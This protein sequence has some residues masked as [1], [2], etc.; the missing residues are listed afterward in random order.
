MSPEQLHI[1]QHSLGVDQYGRGQMYRDHFVTGEG[2]ADHP[3][4]MFLVERGDMV[5]YPSV[6]LY[7]GMDL[8]R[9]TQ[10]GRESVMAFSPASPKLS[11]SQ[12][13]YA[14]YLEADSSL[15]FGEWLKARF[16]KREA[17]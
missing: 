13:R 16:G 5:R 3:I 12:K 1:L 4:C 14:D 17:A 6:D 10:Q 11:R 8:F 2:S 7:G 9:V 15:S